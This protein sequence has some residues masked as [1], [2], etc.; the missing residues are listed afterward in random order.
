MGSQENANLLLNELSKNTTCEVSSVRAVG[1]HNRYE[2][3][4]SSVK[5]SSL[6]FAMS[7]IA[8]QAS[9]T[10]GKKF[11]GCA[12]S[13]HQIQSLTPANINPNTLQLLKQKKLVIEANG[14]LEPD[15]SSVLLIRSLKMAVPLIEYHSIADMKASLMSEKHKFID[16]IN[17]SIHHVCRDAFTIYAERHCLEQF[18]ARY[19]GAFENNEAITTANYQ[20]DR[21]LVALT[22]QEI[23]LYK[24]EARRLGLPGKRHTGIGWVSVDEENGEKYL[25]VRMNSIRSRM[26]SRCTVPMKLIRVK[27]VGSNDNMQG[28]I[29]HRCPNDTVCNNN[30]YPMYPKNR[31]EREM[32]RPVATRPT[33]RT[34]FVTGW[35]SE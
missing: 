23:E 35:K 10:A 27:L 31:Y 21:Q 32:L 8:P 6:T 19:P 25:A 28:T 4:S 26:C 24:N 16:A 18:R 14:T 17:D 2:L 7:S 9:I 11:T 15:Q 1:I 30:L 3:K 22:K 20:V 13:V 12:F 29:F 33:V 34:Y 5:C